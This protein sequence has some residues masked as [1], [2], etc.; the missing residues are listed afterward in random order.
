[1]SN[2]IKVQTE[3]VAEVQLFD[4]ECHTIIDLIPCIDPSNAS[5]FLSLSDDLARLRAQKDNAMHKLLDKYGV[6]SKE[7]SLDY[8]TGVLTYLEA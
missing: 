4:I 2:T 8:T 3:E 7:Y 6:K 5:V 1:M